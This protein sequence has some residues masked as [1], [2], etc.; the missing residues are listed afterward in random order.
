M[1]RPQDKKILCLDLRE[2][3]DSIGQELELVSLIILSLLVNGITEFADKYEVKPPK[4]L[5]HTLA[6]I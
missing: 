3:C 2:I 5:I 6:D 1:V 4:F